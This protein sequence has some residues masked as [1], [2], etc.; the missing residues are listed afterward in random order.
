MSKVKQTL[1]HFVSIDWVTQKLE[2]RLIRSAVLVSLCTD[3]PI[4]YNPA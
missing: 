3:E 1:R 2:N 4:G